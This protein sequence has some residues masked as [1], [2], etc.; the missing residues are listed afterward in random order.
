MT[1]VRLLKGK[2]G[3]Y[4]FACYCF[5]YPDA[6]IPRKMKLKEHHL[7][8]ALRDSDEFKEITMVFDKR[9]DNGC[10]LR[11]PDVRIE[12]GTHSIIIECDENQHKGYSCEN[13]RIMQIFQD[14]GNRPIVFI[15]FN[16][17]SYTDA[18]G[19]KHKSCFKTTPKTGQLSVVK[20]AWEER[21]ARLI[22]VIN[23]YM[24][25]QDK[26]VETVHLFYSW[27]LTAIVG[28]IFFDTTQQ[29][30]FVASFN[31]YR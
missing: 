19:K 29:P 25:P 16:P 6:E 14:L 2:Y 11:R 18:N 21:I 22:T 3:G 17:D 27:S 9:V 20:R 10:S 1:N 15:R 12:R 23:Q 4:C 30:C 5:K 13:K 28:H 26:N 31:D 8:D 7:R 24:E